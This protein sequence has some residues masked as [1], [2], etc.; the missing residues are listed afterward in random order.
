MDVDETGWYCIE[1][2]RSEVGFGPLRATLAS[3]TLLLWV[4]DTL[5]RVVGGDR[6]PTSEMQLVPAAA[7]ERAAATSSVTAFFD[8]MD[9]HELA[10][11]RVRYVRECVP[12]INKSGDQQR[13]S[14]RTF[15]PAI[16]NHRNLGGFSKFG[17]LHI[18]P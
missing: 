11:T 3:Y 5:G 15:S 10:G 14:A 4:T 8:G 1:S 16:Q 6:Q 2:P 18:V 12:P 7:I 17:L 9:W 13:G